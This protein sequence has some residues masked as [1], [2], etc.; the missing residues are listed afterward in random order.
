MTYLDAH[1]VLDGLLPSV[2]IKINDG[3]LANVLNAILFLVLQIRFD[4]M[5]FPFCGLVFKN[6][7]HWPASQTDF[8]TEVNILDIWAPLGLC[9]WPAYRVPYDI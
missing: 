8:S 6:S 2:G 7:E 4:C 3:P 5:R 9:A 1:D